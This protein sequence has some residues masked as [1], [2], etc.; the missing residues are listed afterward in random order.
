MTTK[1]LFIATTG[2]KGGVG[3]TTAALSLC[4]H[5]A[6]A[7]QSVLLVDLDPQGSASLV[8]N[9]PDPSGEHLADVLNG[10]AQPEPY[11]TG[12]GVRV[13]AG[14]PALEDCTQPE[15]LRAVLGE[16]SADVVIIDAPPGNA[17]LDRL[18]MDSARVLLAC[19]DAHRLALTGASRVL[20]EARGGGHK[21]A[22]A[23]ILGR[24]DSRRQLDAQ[25]ANLVAGVFAVPVLVVRQDA[26]LAV[27]MH[28]CQLPPAQGRAAEDFAKV[29]SWIHKQTPRNP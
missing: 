27:A 6:R 21:R 3:K 8:L 12:E 16:V 10:R 11:D 28:A 13:L 7:G 24:V 5:Y 23:V 1:P 4:A 29:A 18:A 19:C 2:R 26:A 22:C 15:P 25:A 14:G 17:H 20:D 9:A